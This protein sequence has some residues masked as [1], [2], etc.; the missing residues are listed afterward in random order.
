MSFCS[1][2]SA[3]ARSLHRAPKLI[4]ADHAKPGRR[5]V[6]LSDDLGTEYLHF[7]HGPGVQHLGFL[8][9]SGIALA[10]AAGWLLVRA[11]AKTGVLDAFGPGR[12]AAAEV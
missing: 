8:T 11:L 12:D 4:N 2:T 7:H 3:E 6:S 9:A 5:H 10:G 1:G